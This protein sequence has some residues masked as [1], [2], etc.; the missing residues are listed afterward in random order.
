MYLESCQ[1]FDIETI[2]SSNFSIESYQQFLLK[3]MQQKKVK[4]FACFC[5]FVKRITLFFFADESAGLRL[6]RLILA[7]HTTFL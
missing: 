7:K 2:G 3:N 4:D 6:N 1:E 5:I